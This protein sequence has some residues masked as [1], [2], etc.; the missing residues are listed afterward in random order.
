MVKKLDGKLLWLVLGA[1]ILLS[2]LMGAALLNTGQ[3][4]GDDFASYVMQAQSIV[5][6]SP[7]QFMQANAFTIKQSSINLGPVA[8]P[9][10]TSVLLA[11][12][13]AIF[14]VNMIALKSV[15]LVCYV[16]FLIILAAGLRSKLSPLALIALVAILGLDPAILA[17]FNSVLSDIPFLLASTA[18]ILLIGLVIV[19]RRILI[20]RM[21]GIRP[22][23]HSPGRLVLHPHD[24]NCPVVRRPF[25]GSDRFPPGFPPQSAIACGRGGKTAAAIRFAKG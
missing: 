1:V 11:P 13:V 21:A 14:G 4:W 15:N 9:W 20:R 25:L 17:L 22:A 24:G 16:L 5:H 2:A 6:G 7:S 3:D 8:Y 10:G 12:V 18:A 19:Q 23:R